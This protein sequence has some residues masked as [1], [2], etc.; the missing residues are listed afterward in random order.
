MK[1]I[2][3]RLFPLRE[4][5]VVRTGCSPLGYR[6]FI[7]LIG[8]NCA[9]G[10]WWVSKFW[11]FAI[12]TKKRCPAIAAPPKFIDER[13]I[14]AQTRRTRVDSDTIS[15]S[16]WLRFPSE[17][18]NEHKNTAQN[19]CTWLESD[20]IGSPTW[21]RFL[22]DLKR[23]ETAKCPVSWLPATPTD[24]PPR[25]QTNR[26]SRGRRPRVPSGTPQKV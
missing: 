6:Y 24:R 17:F 8:D 11:D 1:A 13:Q 19:R 3:Q 26:S 15:S 4:R 10:V 18:L 25:S 5:C 12:L 20:T 23:E 9:C 2:D 7:Q 21:L 22:S 14:T 16:T